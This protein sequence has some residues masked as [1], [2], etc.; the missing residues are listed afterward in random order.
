MATQCCEGTLN[1]SED[2]GG[3]LWYALVIPCDLATETDQNEWK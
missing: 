3:M 1:D 2:K